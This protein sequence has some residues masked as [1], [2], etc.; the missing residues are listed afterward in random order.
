MSSRLQPSI[1]DTTLYELAL[2]SNPNLG[3][4]ANLAAHGQN[5]VKVKALVTAIG[6]DEVFPE[7]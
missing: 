7:W 4:A 3:G 6:A 5:G 1:P 2:S